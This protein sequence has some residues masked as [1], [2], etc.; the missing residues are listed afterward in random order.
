[1]PHLQGDD[2]GRH[3]RHPAV[4]VAVCFASGVL[5]DR[6]LPE[7]S[8]WTWS[9]LGVIAIGFVAWGIVHS[10]VKVVVLG[11]LGAGICLGGLRHHAFWSLNSADEVSQFFT[12][13][14]RLVRLLGTVAKPPTVKVQNPA[15][16]LSAYPK[17]DQTRFPLRC[18]LLQDGDRFVPVRGSVQVFVDGRLPDLKVA[19]TVEVFGWAYRPS[20]PANP[21]DFDYADYLRRQQIRAMV[22]VGNAEAVK[23]LSEDKSG[24][25]SRRVDQLRTRAERFFKRHLKEENSQIAAALLLGIRSTLPEEIREQFQESGMMHVLALSGLHVGILAA[26]VW[27]LARIF[28]LPPRLGTIFTFSAVL[29]LAVISGGRPPIVRAAVFLGIASLGHLTCRF[30]T[31]QNIV[32]LAAL[33]ILAWNPTDL[34]DVGA[35]LSFL[36]VA[37]LLLTTPWAIPHY[38]GT[39]LAPDESQI[40]NRFLKILAWLVQILWTWCRLTLGIWIMIGPL[41]A[42]RMHIIAPIGQLLNVVM[43]P[44]ITLVLSSGYLLLF[45]GWIVPALAPA[46]AVPFDL[47]LS[48]LRWLVEWSADQPW[49]HFDVAGPADWWL[50]GYYSIFAGLYALR[51]RIPRPRFCGALL[52]LSWMVLGLAVSARPH[53][54]RGLRATFLSVGHGSAILLEFPGGRTMLYDAGALD[55]GERAFRVIRG[56]LWQRGMTRLDAVAISHGDLDHVNALPLLA[57]EIPIGTV[58]VARSFLQSDREV[59][60]YVVETLAEKE[61]PIRAVGREDRLRLDPEVSAEVLHPKPRTNYAHNNANSLVIRLTLAGRSLLLMGDVE[62]EGLSDLMKQ[63]VGRVDVFQSP[64]HGSPAANTPELVRWANPGIVV[65]SGGFVAGRMD[66]LETLYGGQVRLLSTN[67]DGAVTVEIT[68]QG[69]LLV[70]TTRKN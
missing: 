28:Q 64:H 61:I 66:E 21:G 13:K 2:S 9:L 18:R 45:V 53:S 19:D 50:A 23:K 40:E 10:R 29:G 63:R 65:V 49:G 14:S 15:P 54:P 26:L 7:F 68:P 24:E 60:P 44:F 37:G 69:H 5:L 62:H 22:N 34:F 48:S 1:M 6:S 33:V 52:I 56:A 8:W 39:Q 31:P 27:G 36:G 25:W 41:L 42:A 57:E 16:F 58:L 70:E 4:P 12:Q 59:V 67:R 32:A 11:L 3:S 47:G 43:I 51:F 38:R 35:Q 20:S 30:S 55:D 46:L 17:P